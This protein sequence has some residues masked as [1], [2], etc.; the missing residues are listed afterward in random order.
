VQSHFTFTGTI[1]AP[2]KPKEAKAK[3]RKKYAV[4]L[5]KDEETMY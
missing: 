3:K 2:T 1:A 4:E 5:F